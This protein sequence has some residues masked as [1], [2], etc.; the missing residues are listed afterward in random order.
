MEDREPLFMVFK[1]EGENCERKQLQEDTLGQS[2]NRKT[3]AEMKTLKENH[4]KCCKWVIICQGIS[5]WMKEE[6]KQTEPPKPQEDNLEV[7]EDEKNLLKSLQNLQ[8]E[9]KKLEGQI[10]S[11]STKRE[12][13]ELARAQLP[14]PLTS[15]FTPHVMGGDTARICAPPQMFPWVTQVPSA[16]PPQYAPPQYALPMLSLTGGEMRGP[17]GQTSQ[18]VGGIVEV[19]DISTRPQVNQL[20]EQGRHR[21]GLGQGHQDLQTQLE[22]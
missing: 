11:L 5:G 8:Q 2:V 6:V 15:V 21:W 3:K 16:P 17:A 1:N 13:L 12:E 20:R 9:N 7:K 10:Q 22:A 14:A 18:V 4:G 19:I